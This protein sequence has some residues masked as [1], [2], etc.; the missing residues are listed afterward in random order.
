[1]LQNDIPLSAD[2]HLVMGAGCQL[3]DVRF[4]RQYIAM[5]ICIAINYT[6]TQ[7]NIKYTTVVVLLLHYGSS[8]FI[9]FTGSTLLASHSY[10]V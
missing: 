5:H 8:F 7:Y 9:Q 6:N 2:Y 3:G 1:M 4:S 10:R